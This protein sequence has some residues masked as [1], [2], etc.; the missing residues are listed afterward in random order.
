MKGYALTPKFV[1]IDGRTGQLL[2]SEAFHEETL[3]PDDDEHAGA[4][5]VLRADGQAAAGLPQHAQ[6]AENP[7]HAHPA[8]V[9]RAWDLRLVLEEE[10]GPRVGGPSPKPGAPSPAP[11]AVLS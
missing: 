2:Y 8:Q 6:H 5:V 9:V 4:V 1:F 7:R 10:H 3:Y 11:F